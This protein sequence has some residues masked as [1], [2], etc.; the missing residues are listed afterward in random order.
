ML[1]MLLSCLGNVTERGLEGNQSRPQAAC[2]HP[3]PSLSNGPRVDAKW[4]VNSAPS[5][6]PG[7][8][9]GRVFPL[10]SSPGVDEGFLFHT[11]EPWSIEVGKTIRFPMPGRPG[12]EKQATIFVHCAFIVIFINYIISHYGI[13]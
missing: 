7:R 13:V 6:V 8:F 2:M 5:T 10:C 4:T 9:L 1:R 12:R 11:G 3:L